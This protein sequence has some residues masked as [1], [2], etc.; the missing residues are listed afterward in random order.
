MQV[1]WRHAPVT[2]EELVLDGDGDAA[3]QFMARVGPRR[4]RLDLAQAP[5]LRVFTAYDAAADRWQGLAPTVEQRAQARATK[6]FSTAD[7]IRD[8]IRAAGI[9]IE[10]TP[11]GPK[12]SLEAG[13]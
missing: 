1:V 7:A 13:T 6:D 5:L 8:R 12:W 4:Y 10:D 11:T 2:V 3:G 9:E